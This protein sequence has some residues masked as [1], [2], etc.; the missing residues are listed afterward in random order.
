MKANGT[1][2]GISPTQAPRLVGPAAL[3]SPQ[4]SSLY[5]FPSPLYGSLDPPGNSI[6]PAIVRVAE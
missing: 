1:S 2:E 4:S 3:S 6:T 5:G